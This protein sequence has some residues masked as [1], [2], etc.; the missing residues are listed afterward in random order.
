MVGLHQRWHKEEKSHCVRQTKQKLHMRAKNY[1]WPCKR[2]HIFCLNF[3]QSGNI[4]I[5]EV[6]AKKLALGSDFF[7]SLPL[8]TPHNCTI[9]LYSNKHHRITVS[10]TIRAADIPCSVFSTAACTIFFG[11]AF[12]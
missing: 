7:I 9:Q 1:F 11:E 5:R 8:A 10:I 4:S 6:G 2:H 12:F 3:V